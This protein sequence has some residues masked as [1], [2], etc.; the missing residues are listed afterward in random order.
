M[1]SLENIK[2]GQQ[3]TTREHAAYFDP[4]SLRVMFS[5][6][7]LTKRDVE[8][9]TVVSQ[10]V[11][12]SARKPI[13]WIIA[14]QISDVHPSVYSSAASELADY[15]PSSPSAAVSPAPRPRRL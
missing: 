10:L 13:D 3:D 4:R 2:P 12:F 11:K 15:P 9:T 1:T 6:T 8:A 5:L 7:F 14:S